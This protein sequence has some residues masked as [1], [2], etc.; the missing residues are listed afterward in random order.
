MKDILNKSEKVFKSDKDYYRWAE[1][2][3]KKCS[4]EIIELKRKNL[5]AFSKDMRDG[6]G[7]IISKQ[8]LAGR[9]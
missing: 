3:G 8:Q 7:S 2:F 1:I 5:S 4:K 6:A 9:G